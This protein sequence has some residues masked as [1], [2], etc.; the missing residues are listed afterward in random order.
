MQEMQEENALSEI[1]VDE[2]ESNQEVL[3]VKAELRKQGKRRESKL[4][5][6]GNSP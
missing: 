6:L 1:E 2:T 4:I 5:E 3:N